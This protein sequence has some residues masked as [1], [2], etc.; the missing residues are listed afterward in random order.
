MFAE[1]GSSVILNGT[2]L[3]EITVLNEYDRKKKDLIKIVSLKVELKP[4]SS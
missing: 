3:I 2:A 1:L 4:S